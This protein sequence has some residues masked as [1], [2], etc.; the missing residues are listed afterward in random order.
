MANATS[1]CPWA[2]ASCAV[3]RSTLRE[4]RNIMRHATTTCRAGRGMC[5]IRRAWRGSG[6][7]GIDGDRADARL[8]GREGTVERLDQQAVREALHERDHRQRLRAMAGDG[9]QFRLQEAPGRHQ[10]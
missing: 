2:S 8:D 4:R 1:Y 5:H 9:A 6:S 10:V 7:E 3:S